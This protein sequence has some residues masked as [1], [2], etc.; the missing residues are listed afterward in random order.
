MVAEAGI[1]FLPLLRGE[2]VGER[3][4][5]FDHKVLTPRGQTSRPSPLPSPHRGE[6]V[7]DRAP[8]FLRGFPPS[9][10][11]KLGQKPFAQE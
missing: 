5:T 6:G 9:T 8:A 1:V 7:E 4:E 11:T 2:R 3:G 10:P